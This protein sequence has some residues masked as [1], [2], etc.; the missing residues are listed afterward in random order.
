MSNATTEPVHGHP[1]HIAQREIGVIALTA[2]FT[3]LATVLVIARFVARYFTPGTKFW[4]DDWAILVSL[5]TASAY[6][7][8]IV[9]VE[10]VG[11]AGYHID[12]YSR[13]QLTTYLQLSITI[14]IVYNASLVFSKASVLFLYERIFSVERRLYIWI[15]IMKGLLVGYLLTAAGVLIFATNPIEAQWKY[16]IPHTTIQ[17]S[18]S[19]LLVGIANLLFDIVILAIPQSKVWKLNQS[20]RRRLSLSLIFLLGGFVCISSIV[21]VTALLTINVADL[22]YSLHDSVIWTSIEM[23]LSIVCACLPIL[24]SAITV[25]VKKRKASQLMRAPTFILQLVGVLGKPTDLWVASKGIT[26]RAL[27]EITYDAGYQHEHIS[28][29]FG[30][31]S[32]QERRSR[33]GVYEEP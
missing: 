27:A 33:I 22:T 18:V 4:W 11:G 5:F 28:W 20:R 31:L 9:V 7:I 23:Y 6:L 12:T 15:Q 26:R 1:H 17:Q 24:P 30:F 16:W 8:L 32:K 3:L 29:I 2:V 25:F 14:T 10:T 13:E 21:R 19:Y